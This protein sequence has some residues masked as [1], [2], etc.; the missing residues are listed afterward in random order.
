MHPLPR[1]GEILSEVDDDPR[2]VYF[3]QARY[4]MFIRMALLYDFL[5]QPRVAPKPVPHGNTTPIKCENPSCITQTES[6]LPQISPVNESDRCGY[7]D[8]DFPD[9]NTREVKP[10]AEYK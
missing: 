5:H 6:Y 2:S 4:G 9:L 1:Y 7:C 10:A 8:K 3:E